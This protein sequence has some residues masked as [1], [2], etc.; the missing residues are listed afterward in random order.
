MD[1]C[2]CGWG[3]SIVVGVK[4]DACGCTSCCDGRPGC[5]EMDGLVIREGWELMVLA[6]REKN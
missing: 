3:E 4:S 5:G 6:V 1:C 2:C